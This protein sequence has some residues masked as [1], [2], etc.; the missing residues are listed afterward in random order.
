MGPTDHA[1]KKRERE[2]GGDVGSIEHSLLEVL[3]SQGDR[4]TLRNY[5]GIW[6]WEDGKQKIQEEKKGE[7]DFELSFE[8]FL[9]LKRWLAIGA[10]WYSD[11]S[12]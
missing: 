11:Y 10:G 9:I 8:V 3:A 4:E 5:R 2:R 6:K 12:W 7:R 1:G